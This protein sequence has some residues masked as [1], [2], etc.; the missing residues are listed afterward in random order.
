VKF[1]GW[2]NNGAQVTEL[3][4]LTYRSLWDPPGRVMIGRPYA[5]VEGITLEPHN[6]EKTLRVSQDS[7]LTAVL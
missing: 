2:G 7:G 1:T 6:L 3:A 5:V 4:V